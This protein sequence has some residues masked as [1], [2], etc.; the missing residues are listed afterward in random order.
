MRNPWRS[1]FASRVALALS[2]VAL[3]LAALPAVAQDAGHD[4]MQQGDMQ[5]GEMDHGAMEGEMQ[6]G[7][8]G[9]MSPEEAAMMAAMEKAM[10][11]GEPH[12]RLAEMAG[13]WKLTVTSWMAPDQPPMVAEATAHR[14]MTMGGRVLHESVEGTMMGMPFEG[15]G[16][17]G[18]DNVTGEYWSTWIDNMSTGVTLGRG[19]WD[20]EQNA[21]VMHSE[22]VDPVSHE[23]KKVRMVTKVKPDQEVFVWYDVTDGDETRT[24]QIVYER[25]AGG[26]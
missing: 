1:P 14:K 5:H 4:E 7:E 15:E 17:T 9:D 24:M 21:L 26:M 3:L 8:M 25:T 12:A 2:V 13:D 16:E 6:H 10:T 19:H 22:Y 11:P 18:Y 23:P 20:E